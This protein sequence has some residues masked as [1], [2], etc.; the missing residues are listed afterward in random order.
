MNYIL[1]THNVW[2]L[3]L[4]I[5]SLKSILHKVVYC[6]I[7]ENKFITT[8]KKICTSQ[9]YTFK[10]IV[11]DHLLSSHKINTLVDTPWS[12]INQDEKFLKFLKNK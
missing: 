3:T 8:L 11:L 2:S 6:D 5:D 4:S 1:V 12:R 7:Q 10:D 9:I